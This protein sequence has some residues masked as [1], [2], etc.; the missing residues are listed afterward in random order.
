LRFKKLPKFYPNDIGGFEQMARGEV[1][2]NFVVS[3]CGESHGRDAATLR[4]IRFSAE[5]ARS[6]YSFQIG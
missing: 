1:A 6:D 5:L 2:D 4:A 3:N